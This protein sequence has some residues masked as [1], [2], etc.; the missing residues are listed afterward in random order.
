MCE[1]EI[2]V[3]KRKAMQM[4]DQPH[5]ET[6]RCRHKLSRL[7]NSPATRPNMFLMNLEHVMVPY[8][9]RIPRAPHSTNPIGGDNSK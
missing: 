3:S 5:N 9:Y 2:G 8:Y 4:N 1:M 7:P 6:Q